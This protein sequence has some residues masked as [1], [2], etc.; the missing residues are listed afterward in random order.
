MSA[1]GQEG[2]S[3]LPHLLLGAGFYLAEASHGPAELS[4]NVQGSLVFRMQSQVLSAWNLFPPLASALCL[5]FG[6]NLLI[7]RQKTL[8][9]MMV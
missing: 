7:R 9:P 1:L 6:N 3:P 2:S 8:D 4:G 5:T